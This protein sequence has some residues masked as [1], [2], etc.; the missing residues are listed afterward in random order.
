MQV[1]L[2]SCFHW[3]RLTGARK[4]MSVAGGAVRKQQMFKPRSLSIILGSQI[5]VGSDTGF[6]QPSESASA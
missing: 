5:R 4:S 6:K 3:A 1:I 2:Q